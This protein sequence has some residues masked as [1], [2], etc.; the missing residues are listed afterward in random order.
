MEIIYHIED[1][2]QR[3]QEIKQAKHTIGFVPTMGFLHDGH[4]RLVDQ[5]KED[6]SF[7]IMSIF[8]NPLQFG[9]GED[10]ERYPRNE[11]HDIQLARH[12][13]VDLL[14][15]PSV[16]TMYKKTPSFQIKVVDRVHVLCG[17]SRPGH[18]DG[19]ATVL[20][21]LFNL[22]LPNRVYFGLKDAQQVAVVSSLIEEFNFPIELVAVETKREQDG[23]AKSS[24]NVYLDDE[25]RRQAVHLYKSLT[26]AKIMILNGERDPH[27]IIQMIEES[28]NNH[29]SGRIDYIE[30]LSYPDLKAIRE[31]QGPIIIALAIKFK[32]ARLID[33][34]IIDLQEKEV[35]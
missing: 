11:Q 23:L 5:A 30:I 9:E 13:G 10:F 14:F 15:I 35:E 12:A 4:L 29:T 32:Q 26:E 19:V 28:I 31:I 18:F 21:K 1:L 25:E 27:I 8:V 20:I 24:R 33:N 6:N 7:V 2:Q 34:L 16:D 22:T 17:K 3:I